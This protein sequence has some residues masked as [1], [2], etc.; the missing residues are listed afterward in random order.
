MALRYQRLNRDG[1]TAF[2]IG[3][4]VHRW[5]ANGEPC[6]RRLLVNQVAGVLHRPSQPVIMRLSWFF[7]PLDL[8]QL[9]FKTAL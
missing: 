5:N 8:Y 3:F 9:G 6:C 2:V 7:S 4:R 1:P